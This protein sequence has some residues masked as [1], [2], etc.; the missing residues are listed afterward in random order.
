MASSAIR[1]PLRFL[2]LS[3]FII[4]VCLSV[5][6]S[7]TEVKAPT[8]QEAVQPAPQLQT[9]DAATGRYFNLTQGAS[10]NDLV[11]R[12]LSMNA[13][14]TAARLGIA[15]ARARLRQAG[16]RPNPTFDFEQK[17]GALTG[18]NGER[19]TMVGFALPLEINGQRQRRMDVAKAELEIAEAEI[20]DRERRL[21]A[22]V[23][24]AY[25]EVL[26]ALRE[27]EM[28]EN[29]T[30]L[31]AQTA[32]IV[33]ARVTEGESAPLELS[34]L[35]TEAERLRARRALIEGRLQASLLRLK[36]VAGISVS[37]PLQVR[38][39]LTTMILQKPPDSVEAALEVAL[40]SRPDLQV[41]RLNEK[42]AEAG[43]RLAQAQAKPDVTAF[44]RYS[45]TRSVFDNTP[46]GVLRDKDQTVS[47]GVSISV[48][49][50]NKNQGAKAEAAIAITQAQRRREFAEQQVRAEV[51]A[52][53][54]RYEATQAAAGIFEQGVLARTA[55][56]VRAIRG[57][58]QLGAFRMT[59]LLSEQRRLVDL[60]REYTETLAER[61]RALADLWSAVGIS[62][63]AS[64]KKD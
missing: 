50:F 57:A 8:T 45:S 26:A 32:R 62:M 64:E 42:A 7:Q 56:N 10:S 39:D 46:V 17:T 51:A 15:R 19:E 37:E 30:S 28:T 14:L 23:R 35:R 54:A 36:A 24:G 53:Y 33:E 58:Y 49:V 38:E 34:L 52:A 16:L 29:L 1:A 9:V 44:T 3:F 11:R 25:T 43:L 21:A 4:L 60:Q 2:I 48:P 61:Y 63:T 5:A 27:L 18:S 59:E 20:A 12:A 55:E 40:R 31:D 47:F 6:L 22:E 41:A 13:E